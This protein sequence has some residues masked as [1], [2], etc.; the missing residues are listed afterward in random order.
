MFQLRSDESFP[1]KPKSLAAQLAELE[2]RFNAVMTLCDVEIY[3]KA[4]FQFSTVS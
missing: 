2:V 1:K 4:L 3:A